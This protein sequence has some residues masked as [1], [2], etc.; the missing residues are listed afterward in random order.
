MNRLTRLTKFEK[1]RIIGVRATQLESGAPPTIDI[2]GM[3]DSIEIAEKEFIAGTIPLIIVRKF[4]NGNAQEIKL[5][6]K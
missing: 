2:T 6:L 3:H 4:P 5:C 1:S